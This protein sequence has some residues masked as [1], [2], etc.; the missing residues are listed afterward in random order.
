M[1]TLN[2]WGVIGLWLT[3]HGSFLCTSKVWVCTFSARNTFLIT[4]VKDF[5]ILYL[6]LVVKTVLQ[7]NFETATDQRETNGLLTRSKFPLQPTAMAF[8]R[9]TAVYREH[10]RVVCTVITVCCSFWS[11]SEF[12]TVWIHNHFTRKHRKHWSL[13]QHYFEVYYLRWWDISTLAKQR[14]DKGVNHLNPLYSECFTE[15]FSMNSRC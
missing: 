4:V 11:P 9:L 14:L 2:A 15:K 8:Y 12:S 13:E 10:C 3:H 7:Y 6:I 5:K 1:K